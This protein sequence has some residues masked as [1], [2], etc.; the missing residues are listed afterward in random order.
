MIKLWHFRPR[1]QST[2]RESYLK[3]AKSRP[4]ISSGR[5]GLQNFTPGRADFDGVQNKASNE[6][7]HLEK[8]N[9]TSLDCATIALK[10]LKSSMRK[11]AAI[12]GNT[13]QV[14]ELVNSFRKK[15]S[16]SKS[17]NVSNFEKNCISAG[18]YEVAPDK[19]DWRIEV[20]AAVDSEP[21]WPAP[22]ACS[23]PPATFHGQS[24][25]LGPQCG[26]DSGWT[27]PEVSSDISSSECESGAE[28]GEYETKESDAMC[29]TKESMICQEDAGVGS[30]GSSSL[31]TGSEQTLEG[32]NIHLNSDSGISD[33]SPGQ[34]NSDTEPSGPQQEE[35]LTKNISQI[36]ALLKRIN[37]ENKKTKEVLERIDR[38]EFRKEKKLVEIKPYLVKK[39][40]EAMEVKKEGET[41][42]EPAE[43]STKSR[44]SFSGSWANDKAEDIT[45]ASSMEQK[46]YPIVVFNPL[47]L[48]QPSPNPVGSRYHLTFKVVQADA[49]IVSQIFHAH[50]F[51]E[52]GSLN[53]DF[54][55]MWTGSH[56]KPQSFKSMLPHQRV[57]HFP[58][59]YELTR[60]D[61]MYKN[62]ERLQIAKG[63]KHFN[64]IPKTFMIPNE[65]SEFAATHHRMRG[66]WIVKPVAS[67]RGRGIFIVNHPNQVPLDEPMVVG[68]YIDN[69]LLING[70]KSDLRLYVLVTSYDPLIIYLYEEGLVR[71]ATVKYDH[72]GKNLWNPCMHLC[73]YSINKYHSDYIKSADPDID[74]Q[75]HKW[76]L[77]AFLKHLKANNI[78]TLQMMQ[79]IEDVI[80]KSILSVEFPVNSASKMFVPHRNNCFELYGFDILIDSDLKPWLIEVNLS[81]SLNTESPI[82]MKI[83]SAMISDL[84][85]V[86]GIPAI[87]PVLKRAQ[88]NQKINN[89]TQDDTSKK[90]NQRNVSAET[91]RYAA[92]RLAASTSSLSQEL[93]KM[94]RDAKEQNARRKGWV[95]IF[96]TA[97]TWNNYGALLEYSS[98]NNLVLHEHLFPDVMMKPAN[99]VRS[100]FK[101]GF[102]EARKRSQSAGPGKFEKRVLKDESFD[103]TPK[104]PKLRGEDE[105]SD[106]DEKPKKPTPGELRVAQYEK[107]LEKGHRTTIKNKREKDLEK[108]AKQRSEKKERSAVLKEK[109][110]KMI[111]SGLQLSEYQARKAFTVYLQCILQRLSD[112]DEE[113]GDSSQIELVL[114]FLQKAALSLRE[115]YMLKAPNS[116]LCGKDKAAVVA[117]ELGDFL[118]H[119]RR[120][121]EL[122]TVF[123]EES[124]M[125]PRHIFEEF[126]AFA[127]DS[128]LEDVLTLQ[129]KLYRCAHIFLGKCLPPVTSR[130]NPLLRT[131]YGI[132]PDRNL[133]DRQCSMR[134]SAR[135]NPPISPQYALPPPGP[136]HCLDIQTSSPL[137][138]SNESLDDIPE[139]PSVPS[140]QRQ[141]PKFDKPKEYLPRVSSAPSQT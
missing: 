75:G 43:S 105:T 23:E 139:D 73:N 109:M 85:S 79:S 104:S 60:K 15:S 56:P 2:E 123:R 61:R 34:M 11:Q 72:T 103:K 112:F 67:S 98:S 140:R 117:K 80:I 133:R 122:F 55:L 132:S 84:L 44:V 81:P 29:D 4:S 113:N 41:E 65:Y 114:K 63:P 59:S 3:Y 131:A 68:K 57:N 1:R 93:S 7:E 71:F 48:S 21:S 100:R 9:K 12:R 134:M 129:T 136:A 121:T 25:G 42:E 50:G 8:E 127:S 120:E 89:L 70:H 16:V 126:I 138:L 26:G 64:F 119:Y 77:S 96:P 27:Q 76:S 99:R 19:D 101:E 91:R 69:P 18:R 125:V 37:D 17:E 111:E 51:H 47:A 124:G 74:D 10:V 20:R 45:W 137:P 6:E 62:I 36:E 107:H 90:L 128:D 95:R 13:D 116:K 110:V 102:N 22:P 130:R 32:K 39:E 58:R 33:G 53:Q 14:P 97:E 78:D 28:D 92:I 108:L 83:K 88:F 24:V 49:K 135:A 66:A 141:V 106:S 82:D 87:D 115:S 40:V 30:S 52:V 94:I 86:V 35:K 38:G 46:R 118:G 31:E 5:D 54:N